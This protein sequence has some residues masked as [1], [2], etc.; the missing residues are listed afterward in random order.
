MSVKTSSKNQSI[1]YQHII[2]DW[3]GTIL[4]DNSAIVTTVNKLIQKK[5]LKEIDEQFLVMNSG[6]PVINLYKK[7]GFDLTGN[8]FDILCHE[9]FEEYST[10]SRN[11]DLHVGAIELL[12]IFEDSNITQSILSA[13]NHEFLVRDVSYKGLIDKFSEILGSEDKHGKSKLEYGKQW[14]DKTTHLKDKP[15][16]FIGDTDHDYETAQELGVDC[17]LVARGV[18]HKS[19]LTP[20]DC[21]VFDSLVEVREYLF[22]S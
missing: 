13:H 1:P 10:L 2:W 19:R 15:I 14:L 4:N 3:N 16:L 7:L 17:V 5:N 6:H 18:Q 12:R 22:G 20:L 8:N 11:C 21:P 9:F